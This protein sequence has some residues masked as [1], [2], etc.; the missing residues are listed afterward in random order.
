MS[1]Y[2]QLD[3]N[4]AHLLMEKMETALD[5]IGKVNVLIAGKT[6]VGKSTLVNT[7][8]Q[9]NLADTGSGRPVTQ[10]VREYSKDGVAT[11]I[12]DTRG[13]EIA[14][15]EETL[16]G[17]EKELERRSQDP[18]PTNHVHVAW[19]CIAEDSRRIEDAEVALAEVLGDY[20]PVL[21][22]ITK[23]RSDSGFR[24]QVIDELGIVQ[25]VVRVRALQETFDDGHTLPPKGLGQL[26][27]LTMEV[28]PEG[29]KNALAA[30][31]KVAVDLKA[32]RARKR[33]MAAAASAAA[34]GASPIP[35]SDAALLVPIQ[36]GMLAGIS[37]IFGIPVSKAFLGTLVSGVF[38][39]GAGYLGGRAIVSNLIKMVP[40]AGTA[41]GG[42]IA[43]GTAA[44]LTTAFGE[45]YIGALRTLLKRQSAE[46]LSPSD[47][48]DEFKRRISNR[49]DFDKTAPTDL[50][51]L[52]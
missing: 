42:A 33:V 5:E 2:G 49:E 13:L 52:S 14:D 46:D 51:E 15:Y 39:S 32:K 36:I 12:I 10:N 41:V 1:E 44:T 21:G 27:D 45:A 17:L 23:A 19:V 18:D 28:I 29:Q 7:I 4:L 40:G 35:F 24:Q 26:V 3:P 34:A 11:N 37:A 38:A 20:V 31:Q 50:E 48:A 25:N 22:V 6:G 47:I 9:G 30:A 16:Q 43:G 8:F